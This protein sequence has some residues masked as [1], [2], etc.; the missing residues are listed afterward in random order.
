VKGVREILRRSGLM[1][2]PEIAAG[3]EKLEA[4]MTYG[5]PDTGG[6]GDDPW[7]PVLEIGSAR[8]SVIHAEDG[9]YLRLVASTGGEALLN[10]SAFAD[11]DANR[12]RPSVVGQTIRQWIEDARTATQSL[13]TIRSCAER[14][15]TEAG[16][17]RSTNNV[18]ELPGHE[19]YPGAPG[20]PEVRLGRSSC[21]VMIDRG[22]RWPGHRPVCGWRWPQD[23]WPVGLFC[24][25]IGNAGPVMVMTFPTF[26]AFL[27]Y[28]RECGTVSAPGIPADAGE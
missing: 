19:W 18:F 25:A 3:V 24:H 12:D 23:D 5:F 17:V 2:D 21:I 7:C 11:R 20:L 16:Y 28:A 13:E 9:C 8:V 10:L 15:A 26:L 14:E 1:A 22:G 27:A 6:N 4:G